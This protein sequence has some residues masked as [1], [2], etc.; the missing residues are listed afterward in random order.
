MAQRSDT[1]YRYLVLRSGE[2][3][4]GLDD[5]RLLADVGYHVEVGA[6]SPRT[7]SG[8]RLASLGLGITSFWWVRTYD[9]ARIAQRSIQHIWLWQ[10]RSS[11]GEAD[12]SCSP[13]QAP[14]STR[15]GAATSIGLCRELRWCSQFGA[16]NPRTRV[17]CRRVLHTHPRATSHPVRNLRSRLDNSS[18]PLSARKQKPA[19]FP[20]GTFA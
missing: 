9:H 19:Y 8:A 11:A 2:G 4:V 10:F 14:T 7:V 6:Y 3:T 17:F 1:R 5:W 16:A 18:P 20:I 15:K 12:K 13:S